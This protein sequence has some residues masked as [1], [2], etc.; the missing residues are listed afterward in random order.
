MK[1]SNKCPKCGSG[2]IIRSARPMDSA[3]LSETVVATFR[4]PEA[5]LF[6]GRQ[7]CRLSACVCAG[8]GF[9][10]FYADDPEE[11]RI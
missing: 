10:E 7:S 1:R 2:D 11:L 9:V 5:A 6:K 3:D 4:K 8:C